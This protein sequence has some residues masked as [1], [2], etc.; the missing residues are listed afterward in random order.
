MV[1]RPQTPKQGNIT[2]TL[3]LLLLASGF[4]VPVL[5]APDHDILCDDQH[6]ATLDIS[7]EELA[8]RPVSHEP[9]AQKNPENTETVSASRL[10]KP[11]FDATVREV[12]A[13]DGE[14]VQE[15][16]A[17]AEAEIEEPAALR[18]RAPG[19]SDDDLVRFKRQM[20]RRDI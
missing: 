19:I 16:D 17:E 9:E 11:R 6:E 7:N 3:T 12:F 15:S 10:L 13:D 8:A 2:A 20:Y 18:I 14:D 1:G 5:A 4:A